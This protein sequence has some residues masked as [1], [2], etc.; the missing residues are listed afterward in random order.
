MYPVI[1]TAAAAGQAVPGPVP[2]GAVSESP[3]PTGA[4]SETSSVSKK[5]FHHSPS[6]PLTSA[7]VC[8]CVCVRVCAGVEGRMCVFSAVDFYRWLIP[9]RAAGRNRLRSAFRIL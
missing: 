3:V 7:G 2:T 5:P 4:V 8:A 9:S 6:A 1:P